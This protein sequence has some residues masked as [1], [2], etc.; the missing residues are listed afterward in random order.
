MA[1]YPEHEKLEKIVAESQICGEFLDWLRGK[2]GLE[3]CGLSKDES[4]FYPVSIPTSKLLAEF[5]GIDRNKLEAEKRT[6]L[7]LVREAG[8]S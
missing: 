3:L 1:D 8:L 5:F 6:M 4:F 7:E 2:R